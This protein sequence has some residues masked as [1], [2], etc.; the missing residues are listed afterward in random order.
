MYLAIAT[1]MH[2]VERLVEFWKT[3]DSFTL[4]NEKMFAETIWPHFWAVQILLL[5]LILLYCTIR[6]LVRVI[7]RDRIL[8]LFFGYRRTE[9]AR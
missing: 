2:Y 7:G 3:A 5:L 1:F 6:E 8:Q 4:A 9:E